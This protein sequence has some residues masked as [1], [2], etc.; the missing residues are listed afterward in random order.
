[1]SVLLFVLLVMRFSE[2]DMNKVFL[3]L[4]LLERLR[5]GLTASD[6]GYDEIPMADIPLEERSLI[7]K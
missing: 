6:P 3:A 4:N 1:M 5:P 2:L 7:V